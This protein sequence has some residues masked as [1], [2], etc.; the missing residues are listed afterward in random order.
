METNSSSKAQDEGEHRPDEVGASIFES[1]TLWPVRPDF[2][3]IMADSKT[4]SVTIEKPI[5]FSAREHSNSQIGTSVGIANWAAIKEIGGAIKNAGK[6][7]RIL[8]QTDPNI[9]YV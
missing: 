7:I 6:E 4:R 2:A 3:A 9:N 5:V 8:S 1:V